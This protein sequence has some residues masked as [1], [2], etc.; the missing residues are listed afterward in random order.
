M[1]YTALVVDYLNAQ[2]LGV[3]AY[4]SVPSK[5]PESFVVV[6]QTGM[7]S[8]ELV[9]RTASMDIDC[10]AGSLKSA[11]H[12]AGAAETFALSMPDELDDVCDVSISTCYNNPDPD[13]GCNRFTVGIEIT[14][15]E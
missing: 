3:T 6:E 10:W 12:L 1:D 9:M 13:S 5:R 2:D 7:S 14:V 15:Q 4:P 8:G 11:V